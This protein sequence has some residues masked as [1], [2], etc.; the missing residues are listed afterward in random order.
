M[1][2]QMVNVFSENIQGGNPAGVVLLPDGEDFPEKFKMIALAK[3]LGYSETAFI[4]VLDEDTFNIRY[5]TPA[6]EVDLCGH[7]TIGSF[8]ALKEWNLIRKNGV[9]K[10]RT[11]AGQLQVY[12]DDGKIT[13]EMPTPEVK[14]KLSNEKETIAQIMGIEASDIILEPQII[15]VGLPDI[16]LGVK[17][18]EVLKNIKPDFE[19]LSKFSKEKEV[20][21]LH[22][23]TLSDEDGI[24][25]YC[26]NF[27]P[28]YDI[29][30]EP[31]TGT[32][33]GSLT[34]Y[35]YLNKKIEENKLNCFIQGVEMGLPS[36]IITILTA[37]GNSLEIKVGGKYSSVIKGEIQ[38]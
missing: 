5:F 6:E 16:M 21:G 13:M 36:E 8:G 18:R 9:F 22:A 37:E 4:K 20:V 12:I 24:T 19:S 17:N 2:F 27:A 15:S 26:R 10:L 23:F 30:E 28:L 33:N 11:L 1:K 31:S 3:K 38:F 7:A 14:E 34:A 35:L 32:S 25:A 29:D